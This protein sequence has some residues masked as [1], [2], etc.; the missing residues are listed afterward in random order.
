LLP[1]K[2]LLE[3]TGPL[4]FAD[5]DALPRPKV[6]LIDAAVGVDHGLWAEPTPHICR[7][8]L[9]LLTLT[10]IIRYWLLKLRRL[11]LRLFLQEN[12]ALSWR[13]VLLLLLAF[14]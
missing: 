10:C 2:R 4:L 5:V 6:L 12:I 3:S 13:A 7:P 1:A 14:H 9:A 8:L 11:Q